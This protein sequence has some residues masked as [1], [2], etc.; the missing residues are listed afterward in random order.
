VVVAVA[1]MNVRLGMF[2]LVWAVTVVRVLLSSLIQT[3]FLLHSTMV[4]TPISMKLVNSL[5]RNSNRLEHVTGLF[6]QA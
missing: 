1:G 6:Q 2:S 3:T 5:L 4:V